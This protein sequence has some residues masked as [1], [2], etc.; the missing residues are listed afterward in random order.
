MIVMT[1]RREFF[2]NGASLA[3]CAAMGGV[4]KVGN[5]KMVWADLV[6][7]GVNMWVDH[8]IG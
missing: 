7:L 2:V 5:T 3:T 1:S 6:H 8:D 4:T